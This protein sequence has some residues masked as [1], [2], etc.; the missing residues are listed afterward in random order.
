MGDIYANDMCE[1]A[2][3]HTNANDN[4]SFNGY[5]ARVKYDFG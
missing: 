2:Y 3:N 5:H 1:I 4:W